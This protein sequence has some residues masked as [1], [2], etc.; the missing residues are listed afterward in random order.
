MTRLTR[1]FESKQEK[2]WAVADAPSDFIK[3]QIGAI[4]GI[5]IPIR[6]LVGKW[7]VSQNRP[8]AD[9]ERVAQALSK[10][11]MGSIV[12]EYSDAKA[13]STV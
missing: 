9:R 12:K 11:P 6:K 3:S 4:V 8:E 7:K 10:E 13:K 1:G 2:P 5:E